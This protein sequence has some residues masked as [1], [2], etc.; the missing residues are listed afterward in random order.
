MDA[1]YCFRIANE[2]NTKQYITFNQDSSNND[3]IWLYYT[4]REN[5]LIL[6]GESN[7]SK[8]LATC[9]FIG[10]L[11]AV[12]IRRIGTRCQGAVDCKPTVSWFPILLR[13][14]CFQEPTRGESMSRPEQNAAVNNGFILLL[15]TTI[16]KIT[17][18]F[19]RS[20]HECLI[21]RNGS[22]P[23]SRPF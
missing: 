11:T 14:S 4:S 16:Q 23:N 20:F 9:A 18:T 2:Q 12:T 10:S 5:T 19:H 17:L 8:L 1:C 21:S 6:L 3:C 7:V 22:T 13:T 15:R